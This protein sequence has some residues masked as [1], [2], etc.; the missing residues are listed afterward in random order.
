VELALDQGGFLFQGETVNDRQHMA[1]RGLREQELF[2]VTVP[3]PIGT[4]QDLL[5]RGQHLM[6]SY[7]LMPPQMPEVIPAEVRG[8]FEQPGPRIGVLRQ[9]Y[10]ASIGPEK[11][12]LKEIFGL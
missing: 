8:N 4:A 9:L 7:L 6:Q 5:N 10:I 1:L 12:V 2:R 11:R 3:R